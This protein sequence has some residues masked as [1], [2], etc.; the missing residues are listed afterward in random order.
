MSTPTPKL[1]N[2][3]TIVDIP[4]DVPREPALVISLLQAA[5]YEAYLVGGCVRDL[6][7]NRVPYDWDIVT[8]ALPEAMISVAETAGIRVVYENLFGTVS[9]IFPDNEQPTGLREIQATPYRSESSYSDRRHPDSVSFSNNVLDDVLRRDFTMNALVYDTVKQ[10]LHDNTGG[11]SDILA[12]TIRTIGSPFERF[13]ED[14]LRIMR[15][16]RF[17]AQLG[18]QI[19]DATAYAMKQQM[20]DIKTVSME[21]IRDEFTKMVMSVEPKKGI[22]VALETGL[23]EIILPEMLEGVGCD[24]SRSHIYDVYTHN[25]NACQNAVWQEWPVHVA[26]AA[27]FHDIGKPRSRRRDEEANIWTFYGHEVIGARMVNKI[28]KRFKYPGDLSE[29]VEKLVRYHMFFSDTETITLSA[30][31]RMIVNVGQDLIWDLMRV[32]RSDRIGMGKKDAEPYRLRKYEAMIEEALRSPLSVTMLKINGNDLM[33][34]FHVNPGPRMGWI[35][36]ALFEEVLDDET[37]NTREYLGSRVKDM[38][39]MS[40]S[41]LRALGEAGKLEK[42]KREA[43]EVKLLRTKHRVQ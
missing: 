14:P 28:M 32:R 19:E 9:Y 23:L 35:L 18:F 38:E 4:F 37:H 20:D 25:L 12:R 31:R 40:D 1:A 15:A 41:D 16:V 17:S 6:L 8:S 33:G 42:D 24:Q 13:S 7:M 22:E 5:G 3:T 11:V 2:E 34:E 27:L 39:I 26:L 30:V 21:R 29:K 43:Q 10:Q 36:N